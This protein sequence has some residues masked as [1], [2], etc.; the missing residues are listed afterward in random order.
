MPISTSIVGGPLHQWVLPPPYLEL[1]AM[2]L[3]AIV[4]RSRI[5]QPLGTPVLQ[6]SMRQWFRRGVTQTANVSSPGKMVSHCNNVPADTF[7]FIFQVFD[8]PVAIE[9]VL[10]CIITWLTDFAEHSPEHL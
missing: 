6:Y 3:V 10:L 5:A 4:L 1:A 8:G 2:Q 7:V 9:N